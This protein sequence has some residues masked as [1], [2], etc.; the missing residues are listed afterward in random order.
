MNRWRVWCADEM[1]FLIIT[2]F[3]NHDNRTINTAVHFQC[4]QHRRTHSTS[5]TLASINPH[6]GDAGSEE[7][8]TPVVPR[9]P[10]HASETTG[11]SLFGEIVEIDVRLRVY[12]CLRMLPKI[13]HAFRPDETPSVAL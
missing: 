5:S 7:G 6:W 2:L 12:V 9:V 4:L 13:N 8:V 3:T 1:S 11:T 10:R